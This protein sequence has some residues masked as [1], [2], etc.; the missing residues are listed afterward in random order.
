MNL[1]F[2]RQFVL[3]A[4]LIALPNVISCA[5]APRAPGVRIEAPARHRISPTSVRVEMTGEGAVLRGALYRSPSY[6]RWQKNHLLVEILGPDGGTNFT[7]AIPF[8]PHPIPKVARASGR[9]HFMLALPAVPIP[10]STVRVTP[11]H[12]AWPKARQ[13][14][15]TQLN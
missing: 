6:S 7:Q 15:S 2:T 4:I 10:G 3:A 14:G 9:S 8:A 12:G 5:T 1:A 13:P 11:Q